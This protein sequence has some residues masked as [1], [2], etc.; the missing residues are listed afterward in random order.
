VGRQTLSVVVPNYNHGAYVREALD[1]ILG[2]SFQPSEVIVIDDA[3]TDNSVAVIEEVAG[4][5]PVVRLQRNEIN[6]GVWW[7]INWGLSEAAGDFVYFGAADDKVLP[8][9]FEKSMALLRAHPEAGLC[10]TL[11]RVMGADGLDQGVLPT[12]VV[13]NRPAYF[14]PKQVS[15]L[16]SSIGLWIQGNTV[17]LR[18]QPLLDAGA[19][20]PELHSLADSFVDQVVAL[21]HGACFIPE[22]LA[23]WRALPDTFSR[24]SFRNPRTR[25]AMV[26]RAIELMEGRYRDDFPPRYAGAWQREIA[27]DAGRAGANEVRSQHAAWLSERLLAMRVSER[28]R[29]ALLALG[30][31]LV[32]VEW[33]LR[34]SVLMTTAPPHVLRRVFHRV[35][36]RLLPGRRQYVA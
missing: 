21:R 2:Q 30:I 7:N 35:L 33:S 3:S 20:C 24:Q 17:I 18:R 13:S 15:G 1:A 31:A 27:F 5:F 28:T 32:R 29:T 10:S 11:T 36:Q 23:A 9:F 16:L 14:S 25:F 19:F 12:A 4:C 8:D 6:R 26:S 34:L 22:P